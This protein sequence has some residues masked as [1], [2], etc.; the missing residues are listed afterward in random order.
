M[1][2]LVFIL[3]HFLNSRMQVMWQKQ[4]CSEDLIYVYVVP[5]SR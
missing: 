1:L 5:A 3:V 4:N 2:A